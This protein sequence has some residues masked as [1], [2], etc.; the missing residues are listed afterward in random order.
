MRS[1]CGRYCA[2]GDTLTFVNSTEDHSINGHLYSSHRWKES[3][4]IHSWTLKIKNKA[5][6]Q[7][8]LWSNYEHQQNLVMSLS[9]IVRQLVNMICIFF[10]FVHYTSNQH[11]LLCFAFACAHVV[12]LLTAQS[13]G[14]DI[15]SMWSLFTIRNIIECLIVLN[16]FK[17]IF[18]Y[19][20]RIHCLSPHRWTMD[21]N[22]RDLYSLK[23]SIYS[24][25]FVYECLNYNHHR[26]Y[27]SLL[28]WNCSGNERR[29]QLSEA[30]VFTASKWVHIYVRIWCI[31]IGY[32][33]AS[34]AH[35]K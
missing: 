20:H 23:S 12:C 14:I 27:W 7:L 1:S 10:F 32:N 17:A 34:S 19:K 28:L 24:W 30:Q 16:I 11:T 22:E 15:E 2:A 29:R 8:Q 35:Y 4:C 33:I 3:A 9:A 18:I 6:C 21:E 25:L 31:K 5:L 26:L 13:V